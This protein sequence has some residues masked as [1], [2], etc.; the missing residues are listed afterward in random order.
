MNTAAVRR[1]VLVVLVSWS[2][3]VFLAGAPS[4]VV[5][6]GGEYYLTAVAIAQGG[7]PPFTPDE[8]ARAKAVLAAR[9]PR[10]DS[11]DL[12]DATWPAR[13]GDRD[14]V[15]FWA[16]ALLAAPGAWIALRTGADAAWA[17]VF[18]NV[19]LL[20]LATVAIVRRFG[21]TA[22][23][24]VCASPILWWAD[25]VHG[26]A[27]TV[28]LLALAI[29]LVPAGTHWA[30]VVIGIAALQNPPLALLLVPCAFAG[31]R[32]GGR[33]SRRRLALGLA[34]GLAIALLHP[35]YYVV[36]FGRFSLL[37][38]GA[39]GVMPSAQ[40]L[41]AVLWDTNLGLIPGNP[42]FVAAVVVASVVLLKR[43][44]GAWRDVALVSGV[45]CVAVILVAAA[46]TPNI[47]HGGTPGLSRYA[48]WLIPFA[49]PLL[50]A[51]G[52]PGP[53]RRIVGTL[54]VLAAASCLWA[55]RPSVPEKAYRP[56][57]LSAMV[58]T[59]LPSLNNP[60]PEVFA[61]TISHV[62]GKVA[63]PAALP[64]CEK[65]LL[66]GAVRRGLWPIPCYPADT[67]PPECRA[68][69]SLCYANR[70][71]QGYRYA[72][73]R[74]S[75]GLYFE[76]DPGGVWPPEVEPTI[77]RVYDDA[78]WWTLRPGDEFESTRAVRLVAGV[79]HFWHFQ[80]DSAVLLV[81]RGLGERAVVSI[82]PPKP[83]SGSLIDGM[84][85]EMV[86]G[87]SFPKGP[88]ERVDIVLPPDHDVLLVVL[89]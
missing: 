64:G 7:F 18:L 82:R 47:H 20:S 53:A 32:A 22:A 86:R 13:S 89:R 25:K 85:G 48:L 41:G 39:R 78:Q 27:F 28:S 37:T 45:A 5:G 38:S 6:D 36:S 65:A 43:R 62:D 1:L 60:L 79:G 59:R 75:S 83:M 40:E 10:F 30:A 51:G 63:L 87:L 33:E 52:H 80:S 42:V 55:Y 21:I 44:P 71:G 61:E 29:C 2:A 57:R 14:F 50:A 68:A 8:L 34:A 84:T 88:E 77:R 19:C 46:Q 81:A 9:D 56:S 16:Y 72:R 66:L 31:W 73:V 76:P 12:H 58:W 23:L 49:A 70:H 54:A 15:H 11:W 74:R 17:F 26:E 67:V 69:G 24:L 4:K 35:A 3:L